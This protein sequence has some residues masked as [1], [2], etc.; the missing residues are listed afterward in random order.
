MG[1]GEDSG[2]AGARRGPARFARR[3]RGPGWVWLGF[4]RVGGSGFGILGLGVE[5][6][7]VLNFC[8]FGAEG[9]Q[10][11]EVFDRAAVEA[12]GLRLIAQ[13][14]FPGLGTGSE[15][16][17]AFGEGEVLFL[18]AGHQQLGVAEA[19]IQEVGGFGVTGVVEAG[20]K[21]AGFEAD[22]AEQAELGGGDAL[23]G[24]E[25]LGID[26]AVDGNQVGAEI[27]DIVEA[28]EDGNGNVVGGAAV[29]AEVLGR[30]G[31]AFG[32]ARARGAE[33]IGAIGSE[34]GS[35]DYFRHLGQGVAWGPRRV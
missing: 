9:F 29:L 12:L 18:A 26:G 10:A 33:G 34:F 31:F 17:E 19:G 35:R 8:K 2:L 15:N 13:E 28:F 14:E 5:N 22:G 16:E 32:S 4:G 24:Q 25:F 27:G 3:G 30:S 1:V 20:G 11:I 6:G 23:D 21:E 7:F